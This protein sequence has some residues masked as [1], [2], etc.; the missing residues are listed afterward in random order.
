MKFFWYRIIKDEDGN[1]D[2]TREITTYRFSGLPFGL[3][4][5]PFLLSAT[6]RELADMYKAEFPTTAALVDSSTFMD[7][8]LLA[9]KMTIV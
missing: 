9:R 6:I 4:C 1:Y 7:T 2:I 8:S 3:T 5:C